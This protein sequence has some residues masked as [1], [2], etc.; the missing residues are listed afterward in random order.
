MQPSGRP[1]GLF[2]VTDL[3]SQSESLSTRDDDLRVV[4]ATEGRATGASGRA[5]PTHILPGSYSAGRDNNPL[6][7][8]H[9]LES[10]VLIPAVK[11][12]DKVRR[13]DRVAA[14]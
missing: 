12:I 6:A 2:I 13:I 7:W 11:Q 14:E 1:K 8:L 4:A 3:V 10:L 5:T 9:Q